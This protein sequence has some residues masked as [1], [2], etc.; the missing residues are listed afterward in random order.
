MKIAIIGPNEDEPLLLEEA[1]EIFD[2]ALYV[3]IDS[4]KLEVG[5]EQKVFYEDVD[6]STFD[7]ILP[8]P[9]EKNREFMFLC[10]KILEKYEYVY[11][12]FSSEDFFMIENDGLM[13]KKLMNSGLKVRKSAILAS[14]RTSRMLIENL[15]F[16]I[17]VR[18]LSG[19][20]IRVTN[21]ETLKNVLSLFK[22]GY[23]RVLEKPVKAESIIWCFIV[24][25][26]IVASFEENKE[27][28]R[29]IHVDTETESKL[30]KIR[31]VINSDYFVVN[32]IRKRNNLIVNDIY[33]TPDFSQFKKVTGKDVS[34]LLLIH[35]KNKIE[36]MRV[37]PVTSFIN[38]LYDS[39][40][41]VW[42]K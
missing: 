17:I 39:I 5:E 37:G 25:D 16:P 2:E 36:S 41:K 6:L 28:T 12:P 32:F 21:E 13:K 24:G 14:N 40:K 34:K 20:G 11:L 3:P 19:K 42:K 33:L 27:T 38:L 4:V 9:D 10:L 29:S 23:I 7:I 15:K 26:E 31:R 30:L 35:L 8:L 18:S 1:K 22:A